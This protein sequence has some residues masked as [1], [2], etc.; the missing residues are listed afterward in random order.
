MKLGIALGGG[1]AKGFAHI[2]VLKVLKEAGISLDIVAGTSVGALIGAFYADNNLE[3]LEEETRNIKLTEIPRLLSP[4]WSRQGFFSGNNALERVGGLLDALTIEQLK[5]PYAAISVDLI[6]SKVVTFTSG[7]LRQALRAS[8]SIPAVFTPVQYEQ[9]LLVDGGTLEPVPVEAT[10]AL[11]GDFVIAI[12]LFGNAAKGWETRSLFDLHQLPAPLVTALDYIR[13][14]SAKTPL[15][16]WF[17]PKDEQSVQLPSVI[18]II[19]RT[20]QISQQSI[21]QSRLREFPPNILI[22][23]DVSD[24][25]LLDFHRG[26]CGIERGIAAATAALPAIETALSRSKI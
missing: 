6:T 12:D 1:G 14:V 4:T 18:E 23:P 20:L 13:S 11:G 26:D 2:G 25:G 7:N 22:Q 17:D 9:M 8:I 21:T 10:K 15:A 24:I 19:E 3:K 5:K 16:E